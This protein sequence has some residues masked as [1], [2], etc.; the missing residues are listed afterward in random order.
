VPIEDSLE[1]AVAD[2]LNRANVRYVRD[3][4]GAVPENL[5]FYL[6]DADLFIEVKRFHSERIAAQMS[7]APN[8]IAVQGQAA[9]EWL[10]DRINEKE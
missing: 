6:P 3:R 7:R 8:I 2:A 1:Q 10:C 4:D 9:V 5:D